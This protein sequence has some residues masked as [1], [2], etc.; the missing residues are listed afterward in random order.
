VGALEATAA[1]AAGGFDVTSLLLAGSIPM[2]TL[3]SMLAPLVLGSPVLVKCAA[4]DPVTA[5]LVARSLAEVDAGLGACVQVV[6][7]GRVDDAAITRLLTADCVV[8]TGSDET[9]QSLRPRVAAGRRFVPS[10]HRLSLAVLGEAATR[11]EA[12]ASALRG[13][14]LDVSLWDQ[15]G[16]LSPIAVYVVGDDRSATRRV[17]E[18][19]AAELDRAEPRRPRGRVETEAA[20]RFTHERDAAELR[21]AA[22]DDVVLH[23]GDGFAVVCEAD[24]APRPAPLHRFVRV[25]PVRDERELARVVRPMARHLAGVALAAGDDASGL[26]RTLARCGASRVCPPG[27][28][29]APP[30]DWCHE[31]RGV[32]LP[33]ARFTDFEI[34]TGE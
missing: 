8:A 2:P 7:F 16:C 18:A 19:L 32:L 15:L 23:A 24:A 31:G 20:A 33:L 12:L 34:A 29:Q 25:H 4:R 30:L 9:I 1:R 26:A 22:G 3:L 11:G 14:A 27:R 13:I 17:G 21:A 6:R 5:P 28:L 10:G